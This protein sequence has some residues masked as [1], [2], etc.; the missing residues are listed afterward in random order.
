MEYMYGILGISRQGLYKAGRK[1]EQ[2]ALL[3]QRLRDIVLEVRIDYPRS[4]ARKIHYMLGIKEV[5]INRFERFVSEQ[6]LSV[7]KPSSFI[8]TTYSGPFKYPNLVNGIQ[9][10]GINQLWVSDLTY[11]LTPNGTLYIVLIMDVYSRRIIGYSVSDNMFVTNNQEALEMAFKTRG[12]VYFENLIHHSDKGS[13]YG[14]KVYVSMLG[15]AN[16]QISMAETCLENP[17]AERINGIIK[18]DYLIAYHICTLQQLKKALPKAIELYNN[19]PHGKLKLKSP[20]GFENVL[21]QLDG[22]GYPVMKLY[23]FTK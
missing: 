2:D 4:S 7:K 14:A 10:N 16:I 22:A 1:A 15:S 21:G 23:D 12:Q 17:Y 5:G 13:Q 3:W 18:N 11:F 20:L 6:G 9:L 19:Y 8:R